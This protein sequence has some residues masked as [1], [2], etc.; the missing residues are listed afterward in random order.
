MP[1]WLLQLAGYIAVG[2]FAYGAIRSD[3]KALH[4]QLAKAERS[5]T[6]AHTRIDDHIDR[7]HIK[8]M[9]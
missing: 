4:E 2:G 7:H 1:E 5:A 8:P 3:L 6:R 9:A